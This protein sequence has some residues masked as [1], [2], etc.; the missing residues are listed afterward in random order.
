[1]ELCLCNDDPWGKGWNSKLQKCHS[2]LKQKAQVMG[3]AL[4]TFSKHQKKPG[5][6]TWLRARLQHT[7][8]GHQPLRIP[9]LL[10]SSLKIGKP[11]NFPGGSVVK[12]LPCN[13]GD[14]GLILGRG[15]K[16]SQAA[17]QLSPHNATRKT[18]PEPKQKTLKD[19]TKT[20]CS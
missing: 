8:L 1:M 15:T 4:S 3:D 17:Q 16:I 12:N 7:S 14:M 6:N 5:Q 10:I 20:Q 19:I 9:C 13:A 2:K 11:R 18:V